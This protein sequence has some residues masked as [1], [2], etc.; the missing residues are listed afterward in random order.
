MANWASAEW[1]VGWSRQG[2]GIVS[3]PPGAPNRQPFTLRSAMLTALIHARVHHSA[4][5]R[6]DREAATGVQAGDRL[7]WAVPIEGRR[8][9]MTTARG[10]LD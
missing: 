1:L 10:W 2:S 5:I 4:P 6:P 3:G 9:A 8:P 7:F